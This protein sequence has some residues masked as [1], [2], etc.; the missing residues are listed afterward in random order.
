[1]RQ[2]Y[3]GQPTN[4][5]ITLAA[6]I[7]VVAGIK[8]AEVI[9]IPFLLALF[10]AVLCAPMV[11]WMQRRKVPIGVALLG[12]LLLILLLSLV[13]GVL[14]SSSLKDFSMHL[15]FYQQRIN[16]LLPLA[17]KWLDRWHVSIPDNLLVDH[18]NP[19]VIMKM[20]SQLF[21]AFSSVL[22]NTLLILLTVI[23]LLLEAVH[24]PGKIHRAFKN[25][26]QHFS[27]MQRVLDTI[28]NYM[29]IKTII[30][31]VTGIAVFVW[32]RFQGVDYP[33]LWGVLAFLLNYVPN[34]GSII[35][36]VPPMFLA[37]I[38]L[39]PGSAL[40][41]GAGFVLINLI[42][43]NAIEPRYMSKGLGLSTLVVFLSL[44]FWGWVL[45]PV[46]MLLSVP[47]T[48]TLK[49]ICEANESTHWIS[50]L[51]GNVDSEKIK[52]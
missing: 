49:I 5:L 50:V 15:D 39:G 9:V 18:F 33:V 16:N 10:I 51:L 17:T 21:G 4:V 30:S 52:Q 36:A 37:L 28:K 45:G 43:G 29:M 32:L 3:S 22:T 2:D 12:V 8:N 11:F 13:L 38:Q 19:G 23:F 40:F 47:L 20:A 25:P 7:V 6:F 42:I 26:R 1:M 41:T 31:C 27:D 46:G 14:V 48:M 35:A 24:M 44:I 34:I